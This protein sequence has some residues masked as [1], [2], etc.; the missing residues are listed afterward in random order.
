[1]EAK[2]KNKKTVFMWEK[3]V[4]DYKIKEKIKDVNDLLIYCYKNKNDAIRNL[5]KYYTSCPLD[6]R[7]V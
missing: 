2:L 1:M 3:L 7:S 6:I 5:D 4:R